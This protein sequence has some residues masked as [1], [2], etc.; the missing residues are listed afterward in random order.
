VGAYIVRRVGSFL[1][2]LFT[3]SV[4]AFGLLQMVPGDAISMMLGEEATPQSVEELREELGL[5]RPLLQQYFDWVGGIV[6]RGDFG[7]SMFVPTTVTR[8]LARRLPIT[9]GIA[10]YSVLVA[11]VVGIPAG[12][13]AAIWQGSAWD[14]LTVAMSTLALSVPGFWLGLNLLLL[15]AVVL[16]WFPSGGIG[17]FSESPLSW[18]QALTLPSMAIGLKWAGLL[19][20]MTRSSLLEVVREDYV[21]TARAKGLSEGK[22]LIRH[23]LRN[24]II[25]I[26]TVVGMI[27][28]LALGGA[29]ITERVFNLPG[30][31]SLL[32][33]AITRRDLMIAQGVILLYGVGFCVVNLI[34]DLLYVYLD[35]RIRY[36]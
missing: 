11:A 1:I 15:F 31:G 8:E 26:V 9:L 16:R 5:N 17:S 33:N 22:V 6:T 35:P 12:M 24:G 19:T 25:P 21:T 36:S 4:F 2:T 14:R 28:G 29:V 32:I 18:I 3:L 10:V 7:R 27:V 30:T 34:V 20:R 13:I 23:A